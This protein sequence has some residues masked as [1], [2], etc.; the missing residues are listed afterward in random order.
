MNIFSCVFQDQKNEFVL[1]KRTLNG[2]L[3][4]TDGS[5]CGHYSVEA[6]PQRCRVHISIESS[7]LQIDIKKS[8]SDS[9]KFINKLFMPCGKGNIILNGKNIA[10]YVSYG[11]IKFEDPE[12]GFLK[13]IQDDSARRFL[14]ARAQGCSYGDANKYRNYRETLLVSNDAVFASFC[15]YYGRSR[16]LSGNDEHIIVNMPL[17]KQWC[18]FALCLIWNAVRPIEGSLEGADGTPSY[19]CIGDPIPD[20][21]SFVL[22]EKG[23]ETILSTAPED[24]NGG[25]SKRDY[26]FQFIGRN[27][28]WYLG[29]PLILLLYA[30]LKDCYGFF[31]LKMNDI[32]EGRLWVTGLLCFSAAILYWKIAFRHGIAKCYRFPLKNESCT[33]EQIFPDNN[34]SS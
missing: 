17:E 25:I 6:F 22:L 3:L 31:L 10:Q 12:L 15:G 14:W 1:G 9:I 11:E 8:E 34:F 24:V 23:G 33:M 29:I 5:F 26:F 18:I 16:L 13:I 2:S 20:I 30:F 28:Q 27:C 7:K 21:P 32:P 4:K 19:N